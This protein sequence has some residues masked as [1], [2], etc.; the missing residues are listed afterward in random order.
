MPAILCLPDGLLKLSVTSGTPDT[1]AVKAIEP[2]AKAAS[3][4]PEGARVTDRVSMISAYNSF[5]VWRTFALRHG[6]AGV[7]VAANAVGV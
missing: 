3:G 4:R 5:E 2:L 6:S 1:F 7:F